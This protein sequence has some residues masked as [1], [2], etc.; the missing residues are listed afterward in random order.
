MILVAEMKSGGVFEAESKKKLTAQ[1]IQH[2][3]ENDCNAG[4][5]KAI[6]C[7]FKD[8]RTN[9]FCRDVINKA[10]NIVDNGVME[11]RKT[12]DEEY[13]GKKQIESEIRGLIYG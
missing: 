3:A 9:E 11:W 1:M 13:S 7:V 4:Q 12:S 10:Q 8:D 2:F 6:Y 5:I